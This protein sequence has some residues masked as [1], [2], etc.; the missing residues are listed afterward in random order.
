M[1]KVLLS[2]FAVAA[3]TSCFQQDVL[4]TANGGAISFDNAF[5][6]NATKAI[7][8]SF[9]NNNLEE[10][11]VY[12]TVTNAAQ[13][14]ANIFNGI[15]VV[16]GGAGVGAAWTYDA[17]YTQYWLAG[18]DY[19]F[20]AIVA[21]NE[22]GETVVEVDTNGMPTAVKV[23][24]ASAQND[25]LFDQVGPV[26]YANNVQAVKFTFKHLLAKAKVTVKNVMDVANGN[27]YVVK[28]VHITN[29]LADA[30][31]TIGQGWGDYINTYDL[32]FGDIVAADA[33]AANAEAI[34]LPKDGYGASTF[35]RLLIPQQ[36]CAFTISVDYVL[37]QS[38]VN[39][40][41]DTDIEVVD[42]KT[43]STVATI[44]AGKTYNF[45]LTLGNPGEPITFDV[46]KVEDWVEDTVEAGPIYDVPTASV[47]TVEEFEAALNNTE[48]GAVVLLNDIA[49]NATV[50]RNG[51]AAG[52]TIAKEFILDGNGH[53]LSY[54]GTNR[55]ID[56]VSEVENATIKYVTIKNLTLDCP[57]A[58]R[59]VN[60]NAN[61]SLTLDNVAIN[62]ANYAVNFPGKSDNAV[63]NI[64]NSVLNGLCTLNVW[65]ENMLINVY[66]TEI[67]T[68]NSTATEGYAAVKLNN[69]GVTSA[70]GTVLS[71]DGGSINILDAESAIDRNDTLTGIVSI[72]NSTV[73]NGKRGESAVAAIQYG[74]YH[75]SFSSLQAA[76]DNAKAGETV[77]VLRDIVLEETLVIPAG[78]SVVL[79]LNGHTISQEKA[80][81]ASYEMISNKGN[82][83]IMGNGKLSFKDTGAGDPNFGWG[84]YTV[85]N[86]GTLV[87]ED[88]VIEHLG[89]QPFATH[90]ICAIFQYS[91]STTINGGVISTPNYRSARLWKGE[92]IINGG[93]F[94]GQLWVQAVDNSAELTVNG[95]S[96]APVGGDGSSIFVENITYTVNLAV[97]GG[98]FNTK[99]GTSV[100]SKAGV[101]GT[102]VG[103]IFTES[104]K[105]NT[106][107]A[108]LA[109]GYEFEA[110]GAN[111]K[112]V[113][114]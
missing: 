59:G 44:E 106:N 109:E 20:T 45:A 22:E 33:T 112:V 83:T 48:I 63:V 4:G 28:D 71:I 62:A 37:Y 29:A 32:A 80:C 27:Y 97:N 95:G 8:S 72:S 5:V 84:S 58:E 54:N 107:A 96:F 102:I 55:A 46:V 3:L 50:T 78:K 6:D 90:M 39:G 104:A 93:D 17:Q 77:V 57:K 89:E 21:G 41:V 1:K 26:N 40:G 98:F 111:Y 105:N 36:N 114:K 61:G 15:A 10:F 24:D 75:Y 73:L 94:E 9:N 110:D 65:G 11:Q 2:I 85:R 43:V 66:D 76:I 14:V 64:Y 34:K 56:I 19:N 100:P 101:K 108:L 92:M 82:L 74:I 88:G 53:T 69:D 68:V 86:E 7:D 103:G 79:D 47:S 113:K 91:G 52:A 81:T 12:G 30:T 18:N 60:Y 67:N 23:L 51:E 25:V 49:L 70:E 42:N 35:E 31:Y 38:G 13:E 87:V 99:I 16:K